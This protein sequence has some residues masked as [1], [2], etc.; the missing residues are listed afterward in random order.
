MSSVVT[1]ISGCSPQTPRNTT[2]A[3]IMRSVSIA[4]APTVT[5]AFGR[6]VPPTTVTSRPGCSASASAIGGLVVITLARRSSG[7]ARASSSV[8]VPPSSTTTWPSRTRSAAR[9]AID[10]FAS[11]PGAPAARAASP[12]RGSA[13]PWTRR[14]SPARRARAGRA[15]SCQPR[16]PARRSGRRRARAL[17]CAPG[18]GSG[19]VVHRSARSVTI[20][21]H[22]RLGMIMHKRAEARGSATPE[23]IVGAVSRLASG[24]IRRECL[25]RPGSW[26]AGHGKRERLVGRLTRASCTWPLPPRSTAR[27]W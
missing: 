6:N 21:E 7:S 13:P 27:F 12:W 19:P 9:R 2:S 17:G 10:A 22:A 18:R 24:Q 3:R 16:P 1:P 14:K 4:A 23:T 15:G 25:A 20:H 5:S 26:P 11:G 8:V